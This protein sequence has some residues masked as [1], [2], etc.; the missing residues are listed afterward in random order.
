MEAQAEGA[1][2]TRAGKPAWPE[3]CRQTAGRGVPGTEHAVVARLSR[4]SPGLR[5]RP[6]E[7]ANCERQGMSQDGLK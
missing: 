5:P 6:K 7:E 2:G 1:K 3:P 4:E